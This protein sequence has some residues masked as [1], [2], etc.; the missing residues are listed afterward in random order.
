VGPVLWVASYAPADLNILGSPAA[1]FWQDETVVE[2]L[3]PA[4]WQ[5]GGGPIFNGALTPSPAPV[6][7]DHNW[8]LYGE[9]TPFGIESEAGQR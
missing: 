4:G 9:A 7:P 3:P 5:L 6:F 2:S 1:V 8:P